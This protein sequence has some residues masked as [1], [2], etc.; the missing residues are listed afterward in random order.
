[1]K[2]MPI[3]FLGFVIIRMFLFAAFF[4]LELVDSNNAVF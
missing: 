4:V 3:T 2:S 1:M